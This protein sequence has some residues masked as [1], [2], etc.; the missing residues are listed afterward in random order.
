MRFGAL[1]YTSHNTKLDFNSN[2][3]Q[4]KIA[5]K[6]AFDF[7]SETTKRARADESE[8]QITKRKK[9]REI[10]FFWSTGHCCVGSS[11]NFPN[12]QS[13]M[14]W[15]RRSSG[16]R[17]KSLNQTTLLECFCEMKIMDRFADSTIST[18]LAFLFLIIKLNDIGKE[19]TVREWSY[20]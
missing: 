13:A 8:S 19:W 14:S 2:C 20:N 1:P 15:K 11:K 5:F 7:N 6:F 3:F 10:Q 16:E 9:V 4:S 12:Q 17:R 18:S